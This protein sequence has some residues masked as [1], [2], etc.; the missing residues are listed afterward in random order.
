MWGHRSS[1]PSSQ[2]DLRI[3]HHCHIKMDIIYSHLVSVMLL[4]VTGMYNASENTE[5]SSV[6]PELTYILMLDLSLVV[7]TQ[8]T[9]S[10]R[11]L[12]LIYSIH[13]HIKDTSAQRKVTSDQRQS[14]R[15]RRRTPS[16]SSLN[17]GEQEAQA[18]SSCLSH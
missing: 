4:D 8:L 11:Q 12:S 9:T 15:P 6:R 3:Q 7:C 10:L 16:I 17:E 1:T 5:F 2:S 14:S 18:F 13:F